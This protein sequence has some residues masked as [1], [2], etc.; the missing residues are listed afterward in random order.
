MPLRNRE[1]ERE[2]GVWGKPPSEVRPQRIG[3][4]ELE[5]HAARRHAQQMSGGFGAFGVIVTGIIIII[6]LLGVCLGYVLHINSHTNDVIKEYHSL[7]DIGSD[8]VKVEFSSKGGHTVH[9]KANGAKCNPVC[10]N[11]T[12]G[13]CST[14]F[15]GCKT[16][17]HCIS[18][19][20]NCSG[21]CNIGADCPTLELRASLLTDLDNELGDEDNFVTTSQ[22]LDGMCV[23]QLHPQLAAAINFPTHVSQHVDDDFCMGLLDTNDT[24][25][26]QCAIGGAVYVNDTEE[27][28]I[29]LKSLNVLRDGIDAHHYAF[30]NCKWVADCAIHRREPMASSAS[31]LEMFALL[32]WA[33]ELMQVLFNVGFP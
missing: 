16:C 20:A 5:R 7:Q 6:I 8:C 18:E 11:D 29:I 14:R 4:P 9:F 2:R 13:R 10:Y 22:C 33:F 26:D 28:P 17:T 31:Q 23:W 21:L 25:S 24:Y 15:D 32:R 1:Q 3:Q 12:V 19:A 27:D 30:H